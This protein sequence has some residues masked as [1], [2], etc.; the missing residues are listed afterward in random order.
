MNGGNVVEL[1]PQS[2]DDLYLPFGR[3]QRELVLLVAAGYSAALLWASHDSAV[4]GHVSASLA[5][6]VALAVTLVPLVTFA[7]GWLD[8]FT[9]IGVMNI[10]AFIRQ[11]SA[12]KVGM[13]HHI[14]L[15]GATPTMLHQLLVTEAGYQILATLCLYAGFFV[16]SRIGTPALRLYAVRSPARAAL[17]WIVFSLVIFLGF[18]VSRGGLSAYMTS[19]ES[20]RRQVVEGTFIIFIF[21]YPGALATWWWL[22]QNPS[23]V[24][25]P[26]Y[27]AA[28]AAI[29]LTFFLGFG[30]R[31]QLILHLAGAFAIWC[32]ARRRFAFG[33]AM[34]FIVV[35]FVGV[36]LLGSVRRSVWGREG[37]KTDAFTDS[38]AAQ[39]AIDEGTDEM[40]D[41]V[42][43]ARASLPVF[44]RVPDEVEMLWGESYIAALLVPVPRR[45]WPEKPPLIGIRVGRTFFG[46]SFGIPCSPVAELYWNFHLPGIAVGF[47]L[48]GVFLRWVMRI[49]E[50]YATSAAITVMYVTILMWF[51]S[52]GSD[53]IV[54][55]SIYAV[56]FVLMLLLHGVLRFGPAPTARSASLSAARPSV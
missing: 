14:A 1:K 12:L 5:T 24:R 25:N 21:F 7:R 45:I 52:P 40:V 32:A 44:A 3:G 4:P 39:D 35:A 50:R 9:V 8:P 23:E 51:L 54:T 26:V 16:A 17:P 6:I 29:S 36:S 22:A 42:S 37:I 18:L 43:S 11:Y 30:S 46:Q 53:A 2:T 49:R 48:F 31:S 34:A 56:P 33:W 19:W 28:L 13:V 15:P 55:W 20:G 27:L 10:V 47:F 41:R 38:V